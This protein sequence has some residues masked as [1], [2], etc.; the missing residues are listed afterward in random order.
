[1]QALKRNDLTP[2][3]EKQQRFHPDGLRATK[4]PSRLNRLRVEQDRL[5]RLGRLG[6]HRPK[7]YAKDC[8]AFGR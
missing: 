2:V 3:K 7:S 6:K 1:M 8:L 4:I 5:G